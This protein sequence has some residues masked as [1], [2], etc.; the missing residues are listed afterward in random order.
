MP[1]RCL[2]AEPQFASEAERAAWVRFREVLPDD[3]VLLAGL[4]LTDSAG[5]READLVVG[6]PSV[7]LVFVEVKGG[8]VRYKP[9]KGWQQKVQGNWKD[10]DPVRQAKACKYAVRSYLRR[11]WSGVRYRHAHLVCFPDDLVAADLAVPDCP[12]ERVI[13]ADDLRGDVLGR[14]TA[15]LDALTGQDDEPALDAEALQKM[16]A[17][18]TGRGFTQA[19]LLARLPAREARVELLS[20]EQAYLLRALEGNARVR[21]EGGPGSGKTWLAVEQARRLTLQGQRVALVCY[22]RGLAAYLRRRVATLEPHE[23]PAYCG[24]FHDLAVYWGTRATVGD[25]DSDYWERRLPAEMVLLA[26]QLTDTQKFDAVVVDEAQDFAAGWWEAVLAGMR[27]PGTGRLVLF[28]DDGQKL[29]PR[30]SAEHLDAMV[31]TLHENLRN[32]RPIGD[33]IAPLSTGPMTVRGDDGPPSTIVP[34]RAHQAVAMADAQVELLLEQGWACEHVALLTTGSRHP[35][36]KERQQGGQV[37]Y[38]RSF[39]SDD[40]VFFGH[41]LGFKGLERQAVVLALNGWGGDVE[42][43]REKLYVGLSRARDLLIVCGDPDDVRAVAGQQVL[44]ELYRR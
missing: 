35:V 36:Q 38:W 17:L 3:A 43:A 29:F 21:I 7:G 1:P 34:C 4:D 32:S 27:S 24:T 41:V 25:D 22:S 10:V 16:A 39:F 26:R 2:P 14:V 9:G 33:T 20:S 8:A 23:R 12:R 30:E 11:H 31:F 28:S 37:E 44:D 13:D 15:V 5:D 18:L 19:D 42:R 40:D 6:L